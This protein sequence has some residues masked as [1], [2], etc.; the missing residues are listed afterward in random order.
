MLKV[1]KQM[2]QESITKGRVDPG[3]KFIGAG[4]P[5]NGLRP[6]RSGGGERT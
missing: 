5:E 6:R 1:E 2:A 4:S 3:V